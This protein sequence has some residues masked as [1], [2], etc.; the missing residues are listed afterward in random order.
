MLLADVSLLKLPP[1]LELRFVSGPFGEGEAPVWFVRSRP[2]WGTDS[3]VD[4]S[5]LLLS[6]GCEAA[7]SDEEGEK[8][9]K[10]R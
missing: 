6:E 1:T 8:G 2:E 5:V 9:R 10:F 7:A 3:V 4:A